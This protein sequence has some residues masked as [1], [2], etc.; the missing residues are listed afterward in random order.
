MKVSPYRIIA[1]NALISW[2][3]LAEDEAT[4]TVIESK[5]DELENQVWATNSIKYAVS[6]ISSYLEIEE[7]QELFLAAVLGQDDPKVTAEQEDVLNQITEKIKNVNVNELTIYA[8]KCIHDGWVVDN[9]KKF[10]KEG[11]ENKK[12]QHLP[13]EMI[14]WTEAKADLLFLEP[15][16][17]SVGLEID[18]E[19]LRKDYLKDVETFFK[20]NNFVDEKN[21]IQG[22]KISEAILK[23]KDFYNVLTDV[24]TAKSNEEAHAISSQVYGKVSM[25]RDFDGILNTN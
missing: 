21:Y 19:K 24:N 6:A 12:Y 16:L 23:G 17:N 3:G 5:F 13:L 2:N 7:K 25:H 22:N 1:R 9:A 20:K 11:R 4:K 8:L 10:A 18:S 15:I 14:G